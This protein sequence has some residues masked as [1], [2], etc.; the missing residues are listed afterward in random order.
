M[1]KYTEVAYQ[2]LHG[3]NFYIG[4]LVMLIIWDRHSIWS[5]NIIIYFFSIAASQQEDNAKRANLTNSFSATTVSYAIKLQGTRL[6][7]IWA[8]WFTEYLLGV[9]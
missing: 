7:F 4:L 9:I 1:R 8:L 5:V 2:A 6:V 3:H